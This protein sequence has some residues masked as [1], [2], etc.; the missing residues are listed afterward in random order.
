LPLATNAPLA[1]VS[2]LV[3]LPMRGG[4]DDERLVLTADVRHGRF[5]RFAR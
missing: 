1:E 3:G 5:D 2:S 4:P